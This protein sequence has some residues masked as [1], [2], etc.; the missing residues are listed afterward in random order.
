MR[1]RTLNITV[2]IDIGGEEF[3]CEAKVNYT[4]EDPGRISGP[5]ERCYPPEPAEVDILD[6]TWYPY[7]P[8]LNT[9][10]EEIFRDKCL[11]A[12]GEAYDDYD[13]EA[14]DRAF[15]AAREDRYFGR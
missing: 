6:E 8:Y 11:E 4:P 13:Y 12:A 14:D 15:D 1:S 10:Y 3:T 2:Y 7:A 9:T 5:P